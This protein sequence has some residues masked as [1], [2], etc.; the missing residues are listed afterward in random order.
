MAAAKGPT[1][2]AIAKPVLKS[3]FMGTFSKGIPGGFSGK[4]GNIV[5]GNWKGI[6]YMRSMDK[7]KTTMPGRSASLRNRQSLALLSASSAA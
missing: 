1:A 6:D 7:R 5:G 3:K 2:R 4:V